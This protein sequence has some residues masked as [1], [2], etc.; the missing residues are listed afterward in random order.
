M[1]LTYINANGRSITLKQSRPYF[2]TKIDQRPFIFRRRLI[3]DG[4][5]VFHF[6]PFCRRWVR[7][8]SYV[9]YALMIRCTMT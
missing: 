5:Q 2:I 7:S 9:S 4:N 6:A 8:V 1:E 3:P